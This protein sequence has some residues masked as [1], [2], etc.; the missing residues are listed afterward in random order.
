VAVF[1]AGT[2]D[3]AGTTVTS[4]GRVLAVTAVGDDVDEAAARA[5]D[6]VDRIYYEGAQHRRDIG[7][8]ARR[9]D[10]T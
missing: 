3:D 9:R 7:W 5:Y 8:Q 6:G 2:A 4:G 10:A 1:E